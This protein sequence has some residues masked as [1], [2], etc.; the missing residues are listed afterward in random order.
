MITLEEIKLW[1]KIDYDDEDT[2]LNSLISSSVA[3]IKSATGVS[4]DYI[5]DTDSEELKELYL[6]TQRV[7]INDLY[8][9]RDT[10]NNALISLYTQ[11]ETTYKVVISIG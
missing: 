6:M 7:L 4:I 3:I 8:N 5:K 9:M 11:L 10:E 2:T 1:L